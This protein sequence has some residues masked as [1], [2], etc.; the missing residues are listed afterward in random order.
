MK[1]FTPIKF[2]DIYV[3]EQGQEQVKEVIFMFRLGPKAAHNFKAISGKSI[4]KLSKD[5]LDIEE[6]VQVLYAGCMDMHKDLTLDKMWE[7]VDNYDL[8][9]FA[10]IMSDIFP[11]NESNVEKAEEVPNAE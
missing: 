10:N 7:L 11:Q 4:D 6:I 1:R 3:D 9:E 2:K 8:D 5:E